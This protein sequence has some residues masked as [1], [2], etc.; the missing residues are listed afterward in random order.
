MN[1]PY[2]VLGV[3]RQTPDAEIKQAYKKLAMQH[4]PDREGG[5]DA[6]FKEINEAY[7][8]IKDGSANQTSYNFNST[9]GFADFFNARHNATPQLHV[10]IL[11]PLRDAVLGGTKMV[12]ISLGGEQQVL[13]L[14]IPCGV[15][16]GESIKY[17]HIANGQ[18]IIITFRIQPD[19]TWEVNGNT[20]IRKIDISIWTL[21]TG[22]SADVE[23][24]NGSTVKVRIPARTNPGTFLRVKG[25]GVRTR[26]NHLQFGD[27]LVRID[28]KI[29][30][31]ISDSLLEMILEENKE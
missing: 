27:M 22:G 25:K 21:I 1:D 18:D 14:D 16:N 12:T 19:P 7:N 15:R 30:L 2:T 23:T 3:T 4:H 17:P 26:N 13:S 9:N 5:N 6:K 28:A 11:L 8:K 31:D 29:P 20:I 24:I 10:G